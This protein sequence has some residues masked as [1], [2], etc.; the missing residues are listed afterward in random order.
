LTV[1]QFLTD[2]FKLQ[3]IVHWTMGN[4]HNAN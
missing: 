2:P 3:T 1:V 4:Q